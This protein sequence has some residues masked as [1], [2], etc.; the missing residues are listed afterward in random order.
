MV[1]VLMVIGETA[2][3]AAQLLLDFIRSGIEAGID[4]VGGG[5]AFDGKAGRCSGI[6]V[7][8]HAELVRFLGDNDIQADDPVQIL[9]YTLFKAAFDV[10]GQ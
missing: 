9:A 3:V 2:L 10:R 7:Y 8:I 5:A 4:V 1:R 6:A